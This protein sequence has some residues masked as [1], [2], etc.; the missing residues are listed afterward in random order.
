MSYTNTYN[1]NNPGL[2][3]FL[4]DQTCITSDFTIDSCLAARKFIDF[5][6]DSLVELLHRNICGKEIRNRCFVYIIS[7]GADTIN[8]IS[9]GYIGE[10]EKYIVREHPYPHK[11]SFKEQVKTLSDGCPNVNDGLESVF[12][13]L[14]C[15]KEN[16]INCNFTFDHVPLVIHIGTGVSSNYE[17][18]ELIGNKIQSIEF[19]DGNPIIANF[20]F[21][22]YFENVEI[23]FCDSIDTYHEELKY[24]LNISSSVHLGLAGNSETYDFFMKHPNYKFLFVNS[25][26]SPKDL[27]RNLYKL[28]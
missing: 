19:N 2:I 14:E 28:C 24:F 22:P 23:D 7:Y 9:E 5:I 20:I 17:D 21:N 4:L 12:E 18:L 6:D 10:F 16:T 1:R 27:I 25:K 3:I 11:F 15:W 13:I 26:I 8:M